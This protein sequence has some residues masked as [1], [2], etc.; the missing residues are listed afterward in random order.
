MKKKILVVLLVL[1]VFLVGVVPANAGIL[2]LYTR[3]PKLTCTFKHNGTPVLEFTLVSRLKDYGYTLAKVDGIWE[4]R[5]QLQTPWW[6][7][8]NHDDTEMYADPFDTW[9]IAGIL[10]VGSRWAVKYD[11]VEYGHLH[12]V[13]GIDVIDGD[14]DWILPQCT[15][16]GDAP[17]G[18]SITTNVQTSIELDPP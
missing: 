11:G 6:A 10:V 9:T 13:Y 3:Y 4:G 17:G 1:V 14:V 5:D 2:T 8:P 16:V 12:V 7:T 15:Y 18:G